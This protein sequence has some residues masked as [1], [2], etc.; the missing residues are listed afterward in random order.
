MSEELN[1][2][3]DLNAELRAEV[4]RHL[5]MLAMGRPGAAVRLA[6][7]LVPPNLPPAPAPAPAPTLAIEIPDEPAEGLPQAAPAPE[8]ALTHSNGPVIAPKK[9]GAPKATK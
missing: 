1:E 5:Q 9:R 4:Q 3:G 6:E 7:L 8:D 2:P